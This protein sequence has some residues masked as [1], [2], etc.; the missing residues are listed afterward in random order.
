MY[1]SAASDD[2][3][4][5]RAKGAALQ[6]RPWPSRAG[7]S[8][9]AAA[10]ERF[11]GAAGFER[12]PWLAVAFA[13]GI[14]FWFLLGNR[15]EWLALLAA[16]LA[17]AFASLAGFRGDGRYPFLRQALVVVPLL[18]GAGCLVVWAKSA[19]TGAV[20]IARPIVAELSATVLDRVPR[21]AEQRVRLLLATREPGTGKAIRVRLN[22]PLEHDRAEITQG[23]RIRVK[24]RLMP[25]AAPMLPGSYD[26]ARTAWFA[27]LAAT[28]GALGP[29][30]VLS[31]GQGGSWL[32]RMKVDLSAHVRERLDGSA[33]TIAAALASGDRGAIAEDDDSAMRD[34]GLSHLLSIS[35]LHVSAVVGAAYLIALR[36]LALWP[37]LALRI[38]L[39][40]AAAGVGAGAGIFYTLLTGA[41]VPTVRSCI[42]AVL[43][44]AAL[45]LG[46]EALS[47]RMV[48]VAAFFVLLFW[49]E[50]VI[51]PSFQ[52]SFVAVIAIIALH[53][54]APIRAFMAPREESWTVRS[55]RG[56][57]MLLA[58]GAVIELAIMPIAL[59]HFHRS[60]V[61]GAL[62]NVIAI[63]L[64][65]VLTMPLLFA[66]LVMDLVGAGG[67]AWWLGG[68]TI[69]LM[70]W[71]AHGVSA[72]PGAVTTRPSM[73]QGRMALFVAGG[74][75]LALWRGRKRLWG[76]VPVALG[77]ASLMLLRSPDIL[78]SGDG[79][80]VGITGG[81]RNLLVLREARS[82]FVRDNLTELAGM[83][84]ELLPLAQWSG[85]RCNRDFCTVE[86]ARAG[87]TWR[88]L[89]GHGPDQV[90]ERALA[91]ACDHADIVISDRWL[92]RSCRPA[93]L[94]ADRRLLTRT[95]GLAIDLSTRR[96]SSVAD[97]QGE[98][99]WWRGRPR[100]PQIKDNRSS[101]SAGVKITAPGQRQ[102][103]EIREKAGMSDPVPPESD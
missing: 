54:S 94:K 88:L 14:G 81:N 31:P 1:V 4:D 20:P 75:W 23:A 33:G 32:A 7:L 36:V 17:L 42:G 12:G 100:A 2:P 84:G 44:L 77:A 62:A 92:P 5:G 79:R 47:M 93:L 71:L 25:P 50:T 52:M 66:A 73:G 38:R 68:K 99:G 72:Q 98:H 51:G 56:L 9:L 16:C 46:R 61:Y 34:A 37:W 53:G 97:T 67:P 19:L 55:L 35:G 82:D 30:T 13:A 74:L 10:A 41:A 87:R 21:P 70:L 57:V 60:G 80:H 8:S 96:I 83:N 85:A 15:W 28:G 58:T 95:G 103:N 59:F 63:P 26:F 39:P 101:N 11:L 65:T 6:H 45:A 76:L 3:A 40:L 78:I 18:I 91:A 43:V 90:P 24:A 64:T 102:N 89:I 69:D 27:G 29:V 49:P 86:L 48:A 22:V